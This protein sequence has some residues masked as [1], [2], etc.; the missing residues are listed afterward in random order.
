MGLLSA[1]GW[2]KKEGLAVAATLASTP[3]LTEARPIAQL[4]GANLISPLTQ[5]GYPLEFNLPGFLNP[6]PRGLPPKKIWAPVYAGS[7]RTER[8]HFA[9]IL[10]EE[11]CGAFTLQVSNYNRTSYEGFHF[12]LWNGIKM[13]GLKVVSTFDPRFVNQDQANRAWNGG[14]GYFGGGYSFGNGP[15]APDITFTF[16]TDGWTGLLASIDYVR[17]VPDK[18]MWMT[19]A[20][21]PNAPKVG[22]PNQAAVLLMLANPGFATGRTPLVNWYAPAQISID[23]MKPE[24]KGDTKSAMAYRMAIEKAA[25][26]AGIAPKQIGTWVRDAGRGTKDATARLVLLTRALHD[27][28]IDI[29][30]FDDVEQNVDMVSLLGDLGANTVSFSLLMASYAAYRRN[31]PVMYVSTQD[32][33]SA[34]AIVVLPPPNHTPPSAQQEFRYATSL[35]QFNRPWWGKRLDGKKD[36]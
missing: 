32:P 21:A 22:Q 1:L 4:I 5:R 20:D 3:A 8:S 12:F 33:G 15:P 10:T 27:L 23:D 7:V 30:D 9:K 25:A 14:Y 35:N 34:R 2:G 28:K 11:T 13:N 31:H 6:G 24:A 18:G 36:I 17:Q 16:S 26:N 19:S 29:D